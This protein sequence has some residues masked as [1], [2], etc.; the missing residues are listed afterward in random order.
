VAYNGINPDLYKPLGIPRTDRYLFLARFS[1]VKGPDLAV[2][3]CRQAGVPLDLVGDTSITQEP[4]LY[5]ICKRQADGKR[6]R[7]VGGIPR[8][9]C[10]W[11]YSQSHAMIHPNARF[12]E[13]FGLAPVEAMA[14]GN[15][16]LAFNVGAM[17]E[18]VKHGETGFLVNSNEEMVEHL[19]NN[20]VGQIN[21]NLCREWASTFT[22]DRMVNRY[23][24]LC[25][26]AI[27][28]G[29]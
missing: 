14:C 13:P 8:G 7:I 11:W 20:S 16:V 29:W 21:R 1:T 10:V 17:R 3:C 9:E 24:E 23:A 2:E 28:G 27:A 6:I 5:N 12:R 4:E 26:E 19:K 22:L 15:P 18:T 25:E